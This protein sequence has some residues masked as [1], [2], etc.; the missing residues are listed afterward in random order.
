MVP[1]IFNFIFIDRSPQHWQIYS[2]IRWAVMYRSLYG[3]ERIFSQS[4]LLIRA[5]LVCKMS[6]VYPYKA[7]RAVRV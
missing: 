1:L 4:Y 5:F 7:E 6:K 3:P 2:S